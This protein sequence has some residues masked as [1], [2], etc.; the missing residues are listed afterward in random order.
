MRRE[1]K[2][3]NYGMIIHNWATYKEDTEI[4]PVRRECYND[5][6]VPEPVVRVHAD[7]RVALWSFAIRNFELNLGKIWMIWDSYSEWT[8]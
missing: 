2:R 4:D 7:R 6:V 3:N 5:G 1:G 8:E